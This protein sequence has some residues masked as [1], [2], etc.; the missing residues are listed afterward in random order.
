MLRLPSEAKICCGGWWRLYP[1]NGGVWLEVATDD[2]RCELQVCENA[3]DV[4]EIKSHDFTILDELCRLNTIGE[5]RQFSNADTNA[6]NLFVI[7]TDSENRGLFEREE[8][9]PFSE[10]EIDIMTETEDYIA[11]DTTEI[12]IVEAKDDEDSFEIK[13]CAV[14]KMKHTKLYNETRDRPAEYDEGVPCEHESESIFVE[15]G[16]RALIDL[17][18]DSAKAQA[19][20]KYY[21]YDGT[22]EDGDL[23][24]KYE[25]LGLY[26]KSK[27]C[28]YA[29][30]TVF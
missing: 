26:G 2:V 4:A 16:A 19:V 28:R 11:V 7:R 18:L 10:F 9:T 15:L 24:N 1:H 6:G 22:D 14:T 21:D 5:V 29:I 12:E 20:S 30:R 25:F 13:A 23:I 17:L 8:V 3:D 27:I